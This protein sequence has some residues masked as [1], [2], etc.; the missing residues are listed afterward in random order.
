MA[1]PSPSSACPPT[2]AHPYPSLQASISIY[3]TER[4]GH[5]GGSVG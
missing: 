4:V 3:K 5:F 2:L 1:D